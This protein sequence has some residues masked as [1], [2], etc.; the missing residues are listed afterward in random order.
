MTEKSPVNFQFTEDMKGYVAAGQHA[1]QA[2]HD[3]G[4]DTDKIA[5]GRGFRRRAACSRWSMACC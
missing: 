1:T 5:R 3:Q 2:G 4:L